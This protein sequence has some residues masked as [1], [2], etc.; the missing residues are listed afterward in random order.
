MPQV[1]D[2]SES[3]D[4]ATRSSQ[5]FL[6]P[7]P[8]QNEFS[9]LH[10]DRYFRLLHLLEAEND[11]DSGVPSLAFAMEQ[12]ELG[13][14]PDYQELSCTWS[15][16]YRDPLEQPRSDQAPLQFSSRIL[17]DGK[18]FAITPN[19]LDAL[20]M[21][22]RHGGL[23]YV[24]IDGVCIW[25]YNL[26]ERA[27]QVLLMGPIYSQSYEVLVW[28]GGDHPDSE[29]FLWA[30]NFFAPDI[31]RKLGVRRGWDFVLDY[32]PNAPVLL[33]DLEIADPTEYVN[34]AIRFDMCCAWFHRGWIVQE[35]V[36]ARVYRLCWTFR[37]EDGWKRLLEMNV[38]EC[39]DLSA[40][41]KSSFLY[42]SMTPAN[43][44]SI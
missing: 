1:A 14:S 34:G 16:P 4:D 22:A 13:N 10:G 8:L 20:A 19:M 32:L 28:L 29:H 7:A 26:S 23:S 12:Y 30:A 5:N 15:P 24:W 44:C 18:S 2:H 36:L 9:P 41:R 21:F 39:I 6:S 43:R 42:I 40:Q 33:Q 11:L 25:Q 3:A 37:N 38:N 27:S 31:I 17:V 35:I